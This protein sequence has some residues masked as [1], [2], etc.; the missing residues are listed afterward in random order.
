MQTT[1]AALDRIPDPRGRET[2]IVVENNDRLVDGVDH[3]SSLDVAAF[4]NPVRVIQ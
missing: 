4:E 1:S 2:E 3:P